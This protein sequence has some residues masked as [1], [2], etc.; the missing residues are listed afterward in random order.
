MVDWYWER[1]RDR[2]KMKIYKCIN[3]EC[4]YTVY[5]VRIHHANKPEDKYQKNFHLRS[6]LVLFSNES[7]C[8][9]A[10][11][12]IVFISFTCICIFFQGV[13]QNRMVWM[14]EY[15]YATM[16]KVA[17]GTKNIIISQT[18]IIL[19]PYLFLNKQTIIHIHSPAI[20]PTPF[21]NIY[22]CSHSSSIQI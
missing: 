8:K 13:E 10:E 7:Y 12:E 6:Y 9:R 4:V 5:S 22:I 21:M 11:F 1:E 18:R 16:V 14:D 3:A 19:F 17:L 20:A 15:I 2:V